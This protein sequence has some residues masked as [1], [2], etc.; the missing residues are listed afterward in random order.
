V[1]GVGW[2]AGCRLKRARPKV[3]QFRILCG[4]AHALLRPPKTQQQYLR[5]LL[6]EIGQ[7]MQQH[8]A[9]QQFLRDILQPK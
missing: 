8:R 3:N 6:I 2:L 9:H 4:N 5:A 1:R 7:W